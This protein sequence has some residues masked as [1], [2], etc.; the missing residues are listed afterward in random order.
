MI[1]FPHKK[2]NVV[3]GRHHAR[4]RDSIISTE[5]TDKKIAR[6]RWRLR[7]PPVT[8]LTTTMALDPSSHLVEFLPRAAI[9]PLIRRFFQCAQKKSV[10]RRAGQAPRAAGWLAQA[11]LFER[12]RK[13][14][15]SVADS[16][17]I[18]IE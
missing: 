2:P 15:G 11:P 17:K 9:I 3:V 5:K 14:L 12:R 18:R 6:E 4:R 1:L 8:E 13:Y 10:L 7:F 16:Q